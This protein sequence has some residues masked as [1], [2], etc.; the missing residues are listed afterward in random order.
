MIF[1]ISDFCLNYLNGSFFESARL[2]ATRPPATRLLFACMAF[3]VA[4]FG[5]ASYTLSYI[6]LQLL[7]LYSITNKIHLNTL[8]F[9]SNNISHQMTLSLVQGVTTSLVIGVLVSVLLHVVYRLTASHTMSLANRY[10]VAYTG[11]VADHILAPFRHFEA[12]GRNQAETEVVLGF[13]VSHVAILLCFRLIYNHTT[14]FCIFLFSFGGSYFL[15]RMSPAFFDDLS[16]IPAFLVNSVV[17]LCGVCSQMW[18]V[19]NRMWYRNIDVVLDTS[20]QRI[21]GIRG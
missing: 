12:V 18:I 8:R 14:H 21:A 15:V 1:E 2:A 5:I 6:L 10:I 3:Y 13:G 11:I 20:K 4:F 9:I 19:R 17:M 7:L 16:L